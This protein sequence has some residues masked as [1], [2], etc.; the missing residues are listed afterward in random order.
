VQRFD[1]SA[2]GGAN[3]ALGLAQTRRGLSPYVRPSG[4]G[5]V[6][7]RRSVV[8]RG[9]QHKTGSRTQFAP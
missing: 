3:F 1:V 6:A 8:R 5:A 7:G 9:L 2:L 4:E